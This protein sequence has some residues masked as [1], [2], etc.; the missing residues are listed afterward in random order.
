MNTFIIERGVTRINAQLCLSINVE[1][2]FSRVLIGKMFGQP[3]DAH[4]I[5]WKLG[6]L[7]KNELKST[8][9]LDHFCI[10]WFVLEF[11]DEDDLKFIIK[12]RAW[13]VH[14]QIFHLE[15][16]TTSFKDIDVITKLI[17]WAQKIIKDIT[18]PIGRVIRVDEVTLS[19]KPKWV[20]KA[21]LVQ[22]WRRPGKTKESVQQVS[23]GILDYMGIDSFKSR[24]DVCLNIEFFVTF[25][26]IIV[27][28]YWTMLVLS[29]DNGGLSNLRPCGTYFR[30][31]KVL[32]RYI[33]CVLERFGLCQKW[34]SYGMYYFYIVLS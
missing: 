29:V 31:S 8:F 9:Y 32:L 19:P 17:V 7:W 6:L 24:L 3:L 26:Y 27:L 18:Q 5:K 4:L 21:D 20:A 10:E 15:R 12:N 13:Y 11:T 22:D 16:W 23:A 30:N 28:F 2:M 14:G 1:H 34:I 25:V 33:K